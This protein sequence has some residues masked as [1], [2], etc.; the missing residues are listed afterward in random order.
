MTGDLS[1]KTSCTAKNLLFIGEFPPPYGGVTIKDSL[2]VEEVFDDCCVERFDLYCFKR[3]RFKAPWNAIRLIQMIKKASVVAVGVGHPARTCWVFRIAK[4]IRGYPFL[5]KISVFMMGV[6]TPAY[7]Q[8]HPRYIPLVSK[9]RCIFTESEQLNRQLAD[10][11]CK[12]ARFLPNCRKGVGA[13]EPSPVG[14]IVRFVYFAQV[15]PEKGI[16]TLARAVKALNSEGYEDQFDVAI[17][18]SI[19]K[20][21]ETAFSGLF[22]GVPN[23]TYRGAFDSSKNNVYKELNQYD[24]SVS[25]SSWR[26]GMSGTNIE[27]KFAGITSIVSDAGLNS[28]CV[29]DGVD[30]LLAKPGDVDSLQNAM[31]RVIEDT[32]LLERLKNASYQSR[33]DY[34]VATWRQEVLD[35]VFQ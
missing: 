1:K 9:G 6:G 32:S 16:E 26:E 19:Q 35:V 4:A 34:D 31:R 25:S 13:C 21:Y 15:R 18:G 7:L 3:D 10:L 11:G 8:E 17:Y 24:V 22:R 23:A 14:N 5:G 20:G 2:L 33:I 29:Q 28:E 30:G 12:N 27:S